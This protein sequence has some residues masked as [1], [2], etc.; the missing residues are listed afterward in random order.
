MTQALLEVKDLVKYYPIGGGLFGRNKAY[1][2]AVDGVSFE[3]Y[4][5]ETFGLVGESGCGKT[6]TGRCVLRLVEPTKG[7]VHFDGKDVLKLN[8]KELKQLRADMQIVFQDPYGSL[9]PRL[10][11]GEIVGEGLIAQ[12]VHSRS[13]RE[14]RVRETLELVGIS[15]TY[16]GRYP[17]EFSGGQRQRIGLARALVLLPK[18]VV[19]DEPV[20]ALDVSIQ[21]Q[22]LNLMNSLQRELQLSYLFIAHNLAVVKYVSDRIG[23]MYLGRIV[24]V[25]KS[26]VIYE[27]PR[28]PYTRALLSAIPQPDPDRQ[29]KRIVLSGDVPSPVAPPSGC[30]FHTRC[31]I[32]RPSCAHEDP[33]L[34]QVGPGHLVACPYV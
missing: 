10:P 2:Q 8:G 34:R 19:A 32:A 20:S 14:R 9:D 1:V 33:P 18:L 3:I 5:G 11:I 26:E 7:A 17:H 6:T 28:H 16:R 13:D 24:E 25:A 21:S 30:R 23:V 29:R 31:P 27:D 22:V 12:G 4:P 15:S